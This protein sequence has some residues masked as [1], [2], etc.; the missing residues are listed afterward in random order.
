MYIKQ[1]H[2]SDS[3]ALVALS[4]GISP[5]DLILGLNKEPHFT[6]F[7]LTLFLYIYIYIA[8]ERPIYSQHQE[9]RLVPSRLVPFSYNG[10]QVQMGANKVICFGSFYL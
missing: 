8:L 2:L 6:G 5:T 10:H 1:L 7:F 3:K 9:K 4:F